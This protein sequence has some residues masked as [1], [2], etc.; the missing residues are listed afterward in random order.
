MTDVQ[1]EIQISGRTKDLSLS[2]CGVDTLQLFP[3]GTRVRI[4]MSHKGAEVK[5]FAR[6]VYARAD[7]GMGFAFTDI[8]GEDEYI[9]ESWLAEFVSTPI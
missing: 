5:A 9:L 3:K 1:S 2:G 7:L 4:R 6:V 8:G